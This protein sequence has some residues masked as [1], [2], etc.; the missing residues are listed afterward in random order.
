MKHEVGDAFSVEHMWPT[1]MLDFVC[2]SE[3][4]ALPGIYIV[5]FDNCGYGSPVRHRQMLVTNQ[6]VQRRKAQDLKIFPLIKKPPRAVLRILHHNQR[7]LGAA[8]LHMRLVLPEKIFW[9]VL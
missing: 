4:L 8:L 1:P 7:L 5:T 2:W 3:F 6:S 9:Q